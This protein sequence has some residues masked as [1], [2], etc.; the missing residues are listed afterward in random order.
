MAP[1][2]ASVYIVGAGPGDPSLITVRGLRVLASADVIVHDHLVH[3]RLLRSARPDAERIDVGDAAPREIAQDAICLLLVEKAREGRMVVRLKWGDPFVFDSGGKEA[4][5]LHEQGVPFEVVPGVPAL[6]GVPTYAGIPVTYPGAGDAVTFIRGY[7]DGTSTPPKIDWASLARLDGSIVCYAGPEQIASIAGALLAAG[8]SP[9]D[10][11]ALIHDGTLPHQQTRQLT[12]G[13]LAASVKQV[14]LEGPAVLVIGPV[15]GLRDHLRWFDARPLFGKRILVTRS[16][17]QA[18][19]LIERLEELGAQT[20]EAPS[21]RIEAIQQTE[22]LEDACAKAA[23]FDWIVFTSVN[24]VDHFMRQF[25][26]GR[27]DVRDLKGPRMCAVGP[28]TAERLSRYHVRVDLMPAEDRG[29]AI[30]AA[31]RQQGDLT[32]RRILL[33]RAD[34]ARES[35]ASDLRAAGAEV[36]DV[37]TYHTLRE[38]PSRSS[39]PDIYKLLLESQIDVVTFTSASSVRHF[40]ANIGEEQAADLL[41]RTI[42]ASIGPVTAEAAEQ[43]GI[44]TTVMPETYTI[45]A[46]VDAIVQHV[47]KEAALQKASV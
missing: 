21:I 32:G 6:V 33:P 18:G 31:L 34:I 14:P 36:D 30:A 45:P 24:G 39:D 12:L 13:A 20:I 10:W 16:R 35:L 1:M 47:Q 44:H 40:A 25:L 11:L 22:G 43:L 4:L 7:E 5:F 41:R 19:E 26:D 38:E 8:R 37:V 23:A 2:P 28:T 9:E 42:V 17:E 29:D 27:R 3:P 46:L 15:A